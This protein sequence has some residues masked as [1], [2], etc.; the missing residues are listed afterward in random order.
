M[1]LFINNT[2]ILK[3]AAWTTQ[4]ALA[5]FLICY[6]STS[7]T[8]SWSHHW[9]FTALSLTLCSLSLEWPLVPLVFLSCLFI[10]KWTWVKTLPS[11]AGTMK[12]QRDTSRVKET[13]ASIYLLLCP[14]SPSYHAITYFD[15]ITFPLRKILNSQL[16]KLGY[17]ATLP[18][19]ST[20]TMA[21]KV[22]RLNIKEKL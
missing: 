2:I 15:C 19:T 14:T 22:P 3:Q 12:W 13:S 6:I 17:L 8:V 4:S 9:S 10:A 21:L 16:N 11:C 20:L 7:L 18:F 1:K 5:D